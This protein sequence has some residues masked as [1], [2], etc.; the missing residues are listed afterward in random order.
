M[1]QKIFWETTII[2]TVPNPDGQECRMKNPKS[3]YNERDLNFKASYHQD[4]L[5]PSD[6]LVTTVCNHGRMVF[7]NLLGEAGQQGRWAGSAGSASSPTWD[8]CAPGTASGSLLR[9]LAGEIRRNRAS[10]LGRLWKLI[11]EFIIHKARRKV[12]ASRKHPVTLATILTALFK[13]CKGL[14]GHSRKEVRPLHFSGCFHSSSR[15]SA[16][17]VETYVQRHDPSLTALWSFSST[18]WTTAQTTAQ[19]TTHADAAPAAGALM[20]GLWSWCSSG[21]PTLLPILQNGHGLHS[22][23]SSAY[24]EAQMR[25]NAWKYFEAFGKH[26]QNVVWGEYV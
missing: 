26:H 8:P 13:Y 2:Q 9:L 25:Q 10:L 15:R 5:G 18:G 24:P 6:G 14:R 22:S 20:P 21:V 23:N 12:P 17:R 7:R 11:K 16:R 4:F 1:V 19:T 3:E